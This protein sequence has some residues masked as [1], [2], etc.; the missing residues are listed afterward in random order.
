MKVPVPVNAIDE[1]ARLYYPGLP[2]LGLENICHTVDDEIHNLYRRI[3]DAKSLGHFRERAA[4]EFVVQLNDNFLLRICVFD[5]SRPA[6]S[7]FH[8]NSGGVSTSFSSRCSATR[9]A[10]A[11]IACAIGLCFAKLYLSNRA[12]KTGFVMRCCANISMISPLVMLSFR[13]SRSS[14]RVFKRFPFSQC[15]S[16]LPRCRRSYR[17]ACE[18]S[19]RCRWPSPP[20]GGD[21][22]P[23]ALS[24]RRSRARSHRFR[25]QSRPAPKV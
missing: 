20:N 13:S 11:C 8:K 10:R 18:R 3:N 23:F 17:Y 9:P 25:S 2:E 14:A 15:C 1:C 12:S 19:S 21:F 6:A 4:K 16:D 7:R 24:S 22:R 5:S